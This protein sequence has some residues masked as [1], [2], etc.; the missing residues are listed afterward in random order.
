MAALYGIASALVLSDD[1]SSGDA[2]DVAPLVVGLGLTAGAFG[3]SASQGFKWTSECRTRQSMDE[4]PL[5]D[6]LRLLE[7]RARD[8]ADRRRLSG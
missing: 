5:A 2:G 8:E 6:R 7:L 4:E 1:S 3:Y